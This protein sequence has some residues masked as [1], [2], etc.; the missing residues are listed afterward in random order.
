MDV[1]DATELMGPDTVDLIQEIW[2]STLG[3]AVRPVEGGQEAMT[4]ATLDGIVNI[5][6][7][8]QGA[9]VV[10][11]PRMLA[12]RIAA[13]MFRLEDQTP[14][15]EDM[16]DAIGEITN[17]TGGNLKT[18]MPGNCHLSLPAV[19][20]GMNYSIRVPSAQLVTRL[21]MACE[22]MLVVVSVMAAAPAQAPRSQR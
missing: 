20:E 10:Q 7:D 1:M 13:Q 15:L 16:Q 9:V 8:W 11:V 3:M 18:L 6:G 19:V 2:L 12:I 4:G 22:G 5:T 17:I 21:V 14:T